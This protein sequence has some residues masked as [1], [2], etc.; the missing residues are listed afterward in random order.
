[1][2]ELDKWLTK[3]DLIF[4][5]NQVTALLLDMDINKD[6]SI[7]FFEYIGLLHVCCV[8]HTMPCDLSPFLY[9]FL[10]CVLCCM[11]CVH[12]LSVCCTCFAFDPFRNVCVLVALLPHQ[13][14]EDTEQFKERQEKLAPTT[15]AALTSIRTT[16]RGSNQAQ[17]SPS[18][19][20]PTTAGNASNQANSNV[21]SIQ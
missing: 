5:V 16:L 13:V 20:A 6:D 18:P 9:A 11:C 19:S 3:Q 4:S 8:H 1:M 10:G 2:P 7:D 14:L 12:V 21:C 17:P 15:S